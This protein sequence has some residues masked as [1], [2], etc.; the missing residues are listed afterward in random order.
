M[1]DL[2]L[3]LIIAALGYGISQKLRV[4]VIPLLLIPGILL[5]MFGFG[6]DQEFV[7]TVLELGLMFLMFASGIELN[8]SRFTRTWK[9][10]AFVG[11][12]QF[13]IAGACGFGIASLLGH[14][15]QTA[16]YVACAL[17][18]SSTLVVLRLLK[19]NQQMFEPFGRLVTF[20]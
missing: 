14:E 1:N 6:P 15:E 9:A 16:L 5:S 18:T 17:A 2:A 13:V 7:T 3:L 10:V 11:I 12:G 8:P 19:Q 4:P 20:K